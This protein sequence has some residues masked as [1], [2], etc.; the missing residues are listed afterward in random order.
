MITVAAIHIAPVKSLGLAHPQTV[1][2]GSRGIVEDRRFYLVNRQGRLVTQREMGPLVQVTA[3]YTEAS[4]RLRI[5]FPKGDAIE[6]PVKLGKAIGTP[7]WGRRVWGHLVEGDWNAA[8]AEFC[9][10]SIFL[11]A[12]DEP[13]Q[14][15]DEYPPSLVSQE[16]LER[17]GQQACP[18]PGR[19]AEGGATFNSLRFRPNFLLKGC[20]PHQEDSWLGRTIRIGRELRVNL[21]APDPRCAVITQD[22]LTGKPDV[23]TLSLI[24]SYRSDPRTAYFGVYGV[25]QHPGPVSVGDDVTVL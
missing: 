8:L 4:Q 5:R 1:Q 15:Y 18:E 17:L 23:D 14:C 20:Q 2:V 10:E 6:G 19:R 21:T 25:V 9:G 12:S 22:P 11:V 3:E 7:I 13:G 24:K 16:S